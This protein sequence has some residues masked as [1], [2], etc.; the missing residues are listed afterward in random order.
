MMEPSA[1]WGWLGI[2]AVGGLTISALGTLMQLLRPKGNDL[3]ATLIAATNAMTQIAE[4]MRHLPT[5][6]DLQGELKDTR[7]NL[8]NTAEGIRMHME[9]Q[10]RDLRADISEGFTRQRR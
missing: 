9:A 8:V 6:A 1:P 7:H 4:N 5:K 3:T 2:V 10:I